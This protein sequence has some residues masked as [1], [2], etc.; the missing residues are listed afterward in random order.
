MARSWERMVNKN[1]KQIN[2]RRKKE[3]KGALGSVSKSDIE[4]FK[5]RNYIVPVLLIL[6]IVFYILMSQPWSDAYPSSMT[7]FWVTLICYVL[8]A[9]FYFM[10]R[11]YLSINRDTLETRKFT[12]YKY[13]RPSEIRKFTVEPGYIVIESVKGTNWVF[14]R[15]MNLYPTQ[16][17]AERLKTYADL[18]KV[19]YV[20]KDRTK[21]TIEKEPKVRE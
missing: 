1:R 11:P 18:H 7:M 13:L 21:V 6:L 16:A 20:V 5:G 10:R 8:L 14:S 19:E 9:T 2:Q 12:G 4:K 3:G 17:M 15:W